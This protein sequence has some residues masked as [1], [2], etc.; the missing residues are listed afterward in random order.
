VRRHVATA[1]AAALAA[2]LAAC[3]G[4]P[5]SV[6]N[7]CIPDWP[8]A[9][10]AA[11]VASLTGITPGIRWRT[12]ITLGTANDWILVSETRVAFTGGG[13]LYLLDH[14]GNYL[15]GRTSAA[16]ER[17]SS[18]VA[19]AD[20]NYYFVGQNAY[21]TDA[22][23]NL[24][25]MTPLDGVRYDAPNAGKTAALS[26]DG[27]LYVG[28][29]DGAVYALSTV[30]GSRRFRIE[31][32]PGEGTP[33]I[34]G[35]AGGALLVLSRAAEPKAQLFD[36]RTGTRLA[37]WPSTDGERFGLMFGASLGIVTQRMADHGGPYPWM[38]I[39]VLDHCSK[40]RFSLPATR[41]QWPSLIGFDDALYVVSRDDVERSA[42]SVSVYAASGQLAQGPSPVAPPW[43]LGADGTLY[44]LECDTP[45]HDGPSRLIA[46]DPALAELWRVELGAS[47]P[48][49]G[50]VIDA[51]GHLYFTWYI[52]GA[53]E[54]VSV[55][56]QSPGLA[57]TAWP[58]RRRDARGTAWLQ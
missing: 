31:L 42:T 43:A 4:P 40:E 33:V 47:C 23:G 51:E 3:Q 16:F 18:A 49:A 14:D 24:R 55:Q 29:S 37:R 45:G 52:E 26:P 38:D 25:W 7:Q 8:A 6:E 12:P 1:A 48:A 9:T 39:A 28:A 46:Y 21:S 22:D 53:T 54:V 15:G 35:G 20:G 5:R 58:V 44:G 50:P 32:T 56:T 2:A 27:T 30:D 36:A 10:P 11:P 13:R 34:G 57:P 17:V 41:P 19:D